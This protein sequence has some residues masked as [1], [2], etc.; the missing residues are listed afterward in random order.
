[1]FIELISAVGGE[2]A[3]KKQNTEAKDLSPTKWYHLQQ[4]SNIVKTFYIKVFKL[5]NRC[6]CGWRK[7]TP[8]SSFL[9]PEDQ[10]LIMTIICWSIN[11]GNSRAALYQAFIQWKIKRRQSKFKREEAASFDRFDIDKI[12]ISVRLM[13][14]R[15]L[16]ERRRRWLSGG[17]RERE[18]GAEVFFFFFTQH[19]WFQHVSPS[20]L[21]TWTAVFS[22]SAHTHTHTKH[23]GGRHI[24]KDEEEETLPQLKRTGFHSHGASFLFIK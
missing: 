12:E 3:F 6:F 17:E 5:S 20:V 9:N 23:W 1:M 18:R 21:I 15:G 19:P 10:D 14:Q 13:M 2:H 24:H 22:L 4:E 16:N 7:T 8:H 11:N